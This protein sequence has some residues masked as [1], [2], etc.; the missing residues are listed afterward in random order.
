MDKENEYEADETTRSMSE[1]S[2]SLFSS[3]N[4]DVYLS[5]EPCIAN[6]ENENKNEI[7]WRNLGPAFFSQQD[8]KFESLQENLESNPPVIVMEK[9]PG[10]CFFDAAVVIQ[11]P[12]SSS[13]ISNMPSS[14]SLRSPF[15][16]PGPS[17][18]IQS[19]TPN[20]N[21]TFSLSQS[22]K[23]PTLKQKYNTSNSSMFLYF[24]FEKKFVFLVHH[25]EILKI[26]QHPNDHV[27]Q[28]QPQNHCN[29]ESNTTE[30]NEVSSLSL[31][32]PACIFRIFSLPPT[33]FTNNNTTPT[34]IDKNI[35]VQMKQHEKLLAEAHQLLNL[36]MN[37]EYTDI[38][39]KARQQ[40]KQ[41]QRTLQNQSTSNEGS[42]DLEPGQV[43]EQIMHSSSNDG[44]NLN[45]NPEREEETKRMED[46]TSTHDVIQKSNSIHHDEK[47]ALNNK[48]ESTILDHKNAVNK[49]LDTETTHAKDGVQNGNS[50][51]SASLSLLQQSK[52]AQ[53]KNHQL[54][55]FKKSWKAID[56]ILQYY[57]D[58]SSQS[59]CLATHC[60]KDD[61]SDLKNLLEAA[62]NGI[63]NCYTDNSKNGNTQLQ[64]SSNSYEYYTNDLIITHEKIEDAM[65]K[66][67]PSTKKVRKKKLRAHLNQNNAQQ[68]MSNS[69]YK[70]Q[71]NTQGSLQSPRN[72]L[73]I[74]SPSV[75]QDSTSETL[76]SLVML[77]QKNLVSK[78]R[79]MVLPKRCEK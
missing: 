30:T 10:M 37:Q 11:I 52:Q 70:S 51:K 57:C 34:T 2:Y 71:M 18:M 78:H 79:S 64:N 48:C 24:R 9:D 13:N 58:P 76:E 74:E 16:S 26:L 42:S 20:T 31:Q 1:Y 19:T 66:L 38:Y 3:N 54:T 59:Y 68:S 14:P 46:I 7:T 40:H 39:T 43:E 60:S 41:H 50:H 23:N 53:I 4:N 69:P 55:N 22:P 15:T 25:D 61:E 72:S 63:T 75:T 62:A 5:I 32:F 29:S 73:S 44:D 56:T 6:T 28:T 8:E 49:E 45:E 33:S 67:F 17:K 36:F 27:S 12:K 77:Y 65:S 35:T 47:S 21:S